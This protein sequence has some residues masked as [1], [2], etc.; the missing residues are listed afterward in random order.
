MSRKQRHSATASTKPPG[1]P[2]SS[3]TSSRSWTPRRLPA[4]SSVTAPPGCCGGTRSDRS[5]QPPPTGAAAAE[6]KTDEAS[7]PLPPDNLGQGQTPRPAQLA[8]HHREE[9]RRS[10][11]SDKVIDGRCYQSVLRRETDKRH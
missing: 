3:S 1:S 7:T 11:I 5:G 10:C 9:L 8:P 6:L 2:T 4:L